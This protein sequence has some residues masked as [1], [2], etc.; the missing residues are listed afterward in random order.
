MSREDKKASHC[1]LFE[2]HFDNQL[3]RFCCLRYSCQSF[4]PATARFY[5]CF[6]SHT[7]WHKHAFLSHSTFFNL[8]RCV[9]KL[10]NFCLCASFCFV[11]LFSYRFVYSLATQR[12]CR[13]RKISTPQLCRSWWM[14]ALTR[15]RRTMW[16]IECAIE[17]VTRIHIHVVE[18]KCGNICALTQMCCTSC[19][20]LSSS[21]T[22]TVALT[23]FSYTYQFIH[24]S[25]VW[26]HLYSISARHSFCMVL[27][28]SHRFEYRLAAQ[29]SLRPCQM[30]TLQLCR[31]WWLQEL[32]RRR[33]T[34]WEI[35]DWI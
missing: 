3:D 30:V 11:L 16:E 8:F 21:L 17:A 9:V 19:V 34:M 29:R 26:C 1:T 6:L 27:L 22:H 15:R 33:R 2:D 18:S 10:F 12:L 13:P 35:I 31:S 23:L 7:Q 14:R 32:T 24:F 28:F 5:L 20:F 4:C 25:P